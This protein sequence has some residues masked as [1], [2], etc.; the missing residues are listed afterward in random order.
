M[1]IKIFKINQ[2]SGYLLVRLILGYVFLVAGL[3]KFIFPDNMG[4]G[5]F[6]D[7]GF[8]FPE[9]TAYF[10]G[11]FEAL[12]GLLIL[13]G[14][15]SRLAAIPLV[16]TMVV[17]IIITKFPQFSDG[18]WT[19]AHSARLDIS[20]LLTA[21]FVVFNGSGKHSLDEKFFTGPGS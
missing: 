15:A 14:F 4:P 21:L 1:K 12:G 8:P 6:V 9:F 10:V 16:I 19:F 11:F 2:I 18:F 17:A 3:Q 20:M 5:R 13:I 7:M